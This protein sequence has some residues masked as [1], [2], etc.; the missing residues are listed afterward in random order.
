MDFDLRRRARESWPTEKTAEYSLDSGG[1]VGGVVGWHNRVQPSTSGLS[2][3]SLA[4][5]EMRM[6]GARWRRRR[7]AA[8]VATGEE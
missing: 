5:A 6:T 7:R 2:C 8:G 4:V 1:A 3:R